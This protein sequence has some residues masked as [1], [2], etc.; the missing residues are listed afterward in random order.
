[1]SLDSN[2]LVAELESNSH[3]HR[4]ACPPRGRLRIALAAVLLCSVAVLPTLASQA[5]INRGSA[6]WHIVKS[7]RMV[8]GTVELRRAARGE[9]A[10]S[11]FIEPAYALVAFG[12]PSQVVR[13]LRVFL[14]YHPLRSP[15][16]I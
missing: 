9:S 6:T 11:I 13:E 4:D 12:A 16:R 14:S 8:E 2:A 10:I 5:R 15:P 7:T 3:P 1:M